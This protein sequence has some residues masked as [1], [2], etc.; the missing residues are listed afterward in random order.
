M[1]AKAQAEGGGADKVRE[2]YR[3]MYEK[4]EDKDPDEKTQI[5]S[6]YWE[7]SSKKYPMGRHVISIPYLVLWANEN[8]AKGRIPYFHFGYKRYGNSFWYTGPLH[9]VQDIQRDFNRMISI[10]S[11]HV[12]GWR[13]KMVAEEGAILKEGAFTSES[14]EILEI[15]RGRDK[16]IPLTTPQLSPE[17]M[18]HRD[19]LLGSMDIV[20][21]VHEVS[22]SQLPQYAQRAPASLYA[23][24]LEQEDLKIAP[25][26]KK[27]NRT[28]K[29]EA[30][31]RL[32][33]MG[34]YYSEKRQ[35]KIIGINERSSIEYWSAKDLAGNYDV[36]LV[37]GVS[38]H[39]SRT[40]QQRM[41]LDLKQA[42][43]PIEWNQIFKLL[44]EGDISEKIRG[45]FADEQRASRENQAF[46]NGTHSKD[47]RNG[48]VQIMV[49]DNH[50]VHADSHAKLA[51]TEEAQKWD[52][53]RWADFNQHLFM[54][55]ALL[56]GM[57][58][59]NQMASAQAA[60]GEE[61]APPPGAGG[62]AGMTPGE[63]TTQAVEQNLPF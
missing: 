39:Q 22:K 34:E 43:A 56:Q 27:I 10:V 21:N 55:M 1:I 58:Q 20:S 19:F 16:P 37:M 41:L 11:E 29:R 6:W 36:K 13:A 46:L 2:K 60:G 24:M 8:P 3:G 33:M 32:S 23:Q 17:V 31:F 49:T 35:V 59:Q 9:H 57:M 51:K 30:Q 40:I 62:Q 4:K 5:V 15:R 44:W 50:A 61:G 47:F 42:G 26:V 63:Q 28:L 14:F 38:I 48:G 54:H 52:D 53:K 7:R 45:D 12:E 18:N 25:M